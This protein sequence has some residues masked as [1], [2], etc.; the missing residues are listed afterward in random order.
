MNSSFYNGISGIKTQQYG[1]DVT[2]NNITGVNTVGF[3]ATTAEFSNVFSQ[4]LGNSFTD[5]VANDVGL[6]STAKTTSTNFAQ[7]NLVSTESQYDLAINGN[8]WFGVLNENGERL[9]TRAGQFNVDSSGNLVDSNGFFVTGTTANN[10]QDGL[11]ID[12]PA[13]TITY[14]AAASQ[15]AIKI[16]DTLV[17]P[18]VATTYVNFSGSL[19]SDIITEYDAQSDSYVEVANVDVYRTSIIDAEGNVNAL[20]ITFTKVIPQA[21][22]GTIWNAEA[23]LSDSDGNP[24]STAEGQL[25]FNAR[26][27]LIANTL[28]SIDNNGTQT[29]LSFGTFYDPAIANSGYDGLI[30]LSG[31]DSERI[32][33]KDGNKQ[34]NVK[35]YSI[36]Q[37]GTVIAS[38]DNGKNIPLY[39]IAVY[40]FQNEQGLSHLSGSYFQSTNNSGDAYFYTNANGEY[41]QESTL[42]SN[43][44]EMSNVDVATALTELLV[45]QKAFDASAKSITTS[46][47]LIQNAINMKK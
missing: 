19:D 4:A 2:A 44:L 30:S 34:G 37:D 5:P 15:T 41:V 17:I 43:M 25:N 18:P 3:K 7:G 47:E 20:D 6:G 22:E 33:T 39:K 10:V 14:D 24:I 29:T 13:M 12:D 42:S 11:I 28:T 32:T 8:G 36:N 31:V 26:G 9:Y 16:P 45:M 21:Q 1:I 23:I 46:D 27:A 35:N 40:N 38:F